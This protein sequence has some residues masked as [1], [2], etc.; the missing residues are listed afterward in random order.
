MNETESISAY[1]SRVLAIVNQMKRYGEKI[2][3][4]N[5]MEKILRSLTPKFEHVVVAI[6]ESKDLKAM[7]IDQLMG[8]LEI[9]E[10]RISKKFTSF[11]EQALQSKLSL[12]EEKAESSARK[13]QR[14]RSFEGHGRG[15]TT[16]IYTYCDKIWRQIKNLSLKGVLRL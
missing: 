13:L 5:V 9:H 6:E 16:T 8:T 14:G 11:L 12:K 7:S 1:F 4:V 2:D 3:D 10:Q 15:H